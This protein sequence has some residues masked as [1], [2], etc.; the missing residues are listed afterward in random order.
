MPEELKEFALEEVREFVQEE[1]AADRALEGK[2]TT[3]VVEDTVEKELATGGRAK[4]DT[5]VVETEEF[6][7]NLETDPT[8]NKRRIA[9]PKCQS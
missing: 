4:E 1:F 9:M 6:G 3:F 5:A 2:A 8:R 7:A